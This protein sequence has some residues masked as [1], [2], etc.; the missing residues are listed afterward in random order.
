MLAL[1]GGALARF[2]SHH[3]EYLQKWISANHALG[4]VAT[5]AARLP[6]L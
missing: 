6:P 2:V 4:H 3:P 1:S 5:A